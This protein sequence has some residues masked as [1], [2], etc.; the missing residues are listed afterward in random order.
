MYLLVMQLRIYVELPF[1]YIRMYVYACQLASLHNAT[2][3]IAALFLLCL[4]NVIALVSAWN[5]RLLTHFTGHL[6]VQCTAF[7]IGMP[8]S[9]FD[10]VTVSKLWRQHVRP[11]SVVGMCDTGYIL[12]AITALCHPASQLLTLIDRP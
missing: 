5:L 11:L 9:A 8:G 1:A 10:V 12:Q 7:S 6:L 4:M 3:T 2:D